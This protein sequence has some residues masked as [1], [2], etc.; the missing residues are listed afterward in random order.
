MQERR[1]IPRWLIGKH[2]NF[3]IKE[4]P[5]QGCCLE[6]MNLK[7]MCFSLPRPLPA[8]PEVAANFDLDGILNLDVQIRICWSKESQGRFVYG[9]AFS[10]IGDQDKENLYKYLSGHCIQQFKQKWWSQ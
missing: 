6:D 2:V 3:S 10:K 8:E 7:G 5:W 4:A 9:T 1:A